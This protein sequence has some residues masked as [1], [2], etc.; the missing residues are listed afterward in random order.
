[1]GS[2]KPGR[3]EMLLFAGAIIGALFFM[4]LICRVNLFHFNYRMN[5][6][7]ASDVILGELIWKSGQVIPDTWYRASETRII[8]TPDLAALFLGI[9]Q[10]M[11]LAAGLACC[12]M[13]VLIFLSIIYFCKAVG[14]KKS[15]AAFMGFL[16]M[17]FPYGLIMAELLYVFAGYY[18]VHVV[19]F[20]VT[21]AVYGDV[22]RCKRVKWAGFS[23]C[24]L[25]AF[26]L[27]L[28]GVRGILVIYGPLSGVEAIRNLYKLYGK[29]KRERHDFSL[30]LWAAALLAASFIG[31]CFPFS[32]GQGLSRNIRKGMQK[33]F[34][35]VIPDMGRAVGFE[36]AGWTGRLCMGILLLL[37]L[38]VLI[39]ILWKMRKKE[40]IEPVEWAY[41]V[42]FISPVVS[43]LLVAFTTVESS[44]RYYFLL[45]FFM[46]FSLVLL[47][48]EKLTGLKN[49]ALICAVVLAL[50]NIGNEY[51]PM[52]RSTEP[53]DSD[54]YRVV[55]FLRENDYPLAYASFDAANAMTVLSNG[56]VRVYPVATLEKMDI[57][58]WMS[59]TDWYCPNMPYEQ[60][61]A[62]VV[63]T[64][65]EEEFGRL[66]EGKDALVQEVGQVGWYKIYASDCNFSNLGEE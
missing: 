11:T 34:T 37:S 54:K 40:W 33:L 53:P 8:C 25:L 52:I 38:Y 36:D 20:F 24:V 65:Q 21:L 9:V 62:Y 2:D 57:C 64:A 17:A 19:I 58:K 56:E 39:R 10:D 42:V 43:A 31:T 60:K 51:L 55:E 5:S 4:I 49:G 3:K 15:Q 32:A 12:T 44:R 63:S 13:T 35:V 50:V 41:L 1:M 30:S 66:L 16:C 47:W 48:K 6:D 23:V 61:T 22:M 59:S 14:M 27:G 26:I 45:P 18:A 29:Q 46:A 28:Q 7:T